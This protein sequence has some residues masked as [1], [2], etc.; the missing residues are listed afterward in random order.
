MLD[1]IQAETVHAHINPFVRRRGQRLEGLRCACIFHGAKVDIRHPAAESSLELHGLGRAEQDVLGVIRAECQR[2]SEGQHVLA[3]GRAPFC[4]IV[5][6]GVGSAHENPPGR[7][8]V[9]G[10]LVDGIPRLVHPYGLAGLPDPEEHIHGTVGVGSLCRFGRFGHSQRADA[11]G[12]VDLEVQAS[13]VTDLTDRH[14]V[15]LVRI[16][17]RQ[18]GELVGCDIRGGIR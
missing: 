1:G 9:H 4:A 11:A 10:Y 5:P 16:I 13:D 17:A 12:E 18:H 2:L 8:H 6:T 15:P 3:F 7:V 14:I